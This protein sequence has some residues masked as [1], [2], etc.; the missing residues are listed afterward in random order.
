MRSVGRRASALSTRSREVITVQPATVGAT[1][2]RLVANHRVMPSRPRVRVSTV[3]GERSRRG[4]F[5]RT[6]IW[7]LQMDDSTPEGDRDGLRPVGDPEFSKDVLQVIL[8]CVFGNV[9]G[10]GDLFVCAAL[11]QLLQVLQY[12]WRE[13][14]KGLERGQAHGDFC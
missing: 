10:F 1:D 9:E 3:V 13:L 8:D 6:L 11:T 14:F 5:R 4:P 2:L 12:T 7:S